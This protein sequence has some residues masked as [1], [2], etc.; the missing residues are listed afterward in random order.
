M[1]KDNEN[2]KQEYEKLSRK[3]YNTEVEFKNQL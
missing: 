2:A 3:L 1:R